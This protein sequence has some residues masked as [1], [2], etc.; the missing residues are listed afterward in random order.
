MQINSIALIAAAEV[1]AVLLIFCLILLFQNR[2]L[3][4]LM[5]KLQNRMEQLVNDLKLAKTSG[6]KHTTPDKA[7][8]H[9]TPKYPPETKSDTYKNLIDEQIELTKQFHQSLQSEQDIVLDLAPETDLPKRAAALR[10]AILLA[11]KEALSSIEEGGEPKWELLKY[12]YER[13]FEFYEDYAEAKTS[14][15]DE[16]ELDAL[17]QELTNAKKRVNNLEK[18]KALYFDLEEQWEASK[19]TAKTHFDNL[20]GMA[21]KTEDSVA[22]E[23]ALENY[24]ASYSTVNTLIENGVN[25]PEVATETIE[26]TNPETA[27]ELRHLR[28]VAADQHRLITK[29]QSKLEGANTT[30]ARNEIVNDLKGEL[31]KQ[32]RFVQEAETCIQLM[33]DELNNANKEITQLKS[34]LMS[35]PS[36]KSQLQDAKEQRDSFELKVYALTSEN[37]KITKRMKEEK[38][39]APRDNG[40]DAKLKKELADLESRYASLEEK[41]LDLKFKQ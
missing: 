36:L 12:K 41:Y 16:G 17:R 20:S 18:F 21:S 4:H 32:Q 30:E 38:A 35:L 9:P 37:R 6:D 31:N 27:G 25:N 19:Q 5:K 39:T 26:V 2:S 40:Q 33:E 3:R 22:F 29:L 15:A 14:D 1:I 23:Q 11:E 28:G 24:H 10:H 7:P 8:P 34:R 13:I